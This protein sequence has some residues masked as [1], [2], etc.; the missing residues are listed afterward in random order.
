MLH[1]PMRT[2]SRATI[3]GVC[4]A[5]LGLLGFLIW[6][7]LSPKPKAPTEDGI[8]IGKP[9][10]QVYVLIAKPDKKLIPVFNLASARLLLMA[11]QQDEASAGRRQRA[12]RAGQRRPTEVVDADRGRRQRA[13]GHPREP[14]GRHR[15]RPGPAAERGPAHR[16][17]LDGVRPVHPRPGPEPTRR[18]RTRS[19]PRSSPGVKRPR[20]RAAAEPVAAGARP[21]RRDLPRLPHAGHGEPAEH[22][23][24][25]RRRS[26]STDRTGAA[27]ALD[28]DRTSSR[29]T[30]TTGML[31]A[32]PEKAAL[33][34]PGIAG[35]GDRLRQSTSTTRTWKVGS[36]FR[37]ERAGDVHQVLRG[38]EERH[39]GDQAVHRRPDPVLR[40]TR[41]ATGSPR[42]AR[43]V[44]ASAPRPD[45]DR[46]LD[47]PGARHRGARPGELPGRLP[48]LELHRLRATTPRRSR[49]CTSAS[50]CPASRWTPRASRSRSPISTPSADGVRI[51]HFYMPPGRGA[52]V[53]QATSPEDFDARADHADLR[54]RRE[55]RRAGPGRPRPG[56]GL[57][58][59][60]PAPQNIIQLLPDGA[61]LS[62]K[63][64]S[65]ATTRHRSGRGSTRPRTRT[66]QGG[67]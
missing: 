16:V 25:P 10:G 2:H 35:R 17:P 37:C 24:G 15:G 65:R 23:H 21:G 29:A 6:G 20:G 51:D 52:V 34:S 18:R 44:I 55:V 63:D 49:R 3:V 31:N 45:D 1:D 4:L 66:A 46:R 32:I 41:A 5:A 14:Q 11:Q 59:Q 30:I 8:V 22:E 61:S 28:L 39:P 57:D 62:V 53:R 54:P 67:G 38:A 56:S 36:V 50:S 42:S 12:G 60:K 7:I 47:V 9:S 58:D 13:A 64:V 19:R 27:A 26:T 33:K 40:T 43:T 48:R